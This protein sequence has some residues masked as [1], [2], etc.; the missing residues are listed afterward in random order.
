V[1]SRVELVEHLCAEIRSI[2]QSDLRPQLDAELQRILESDQFRTSHRSCTFLVHVVDRALAGEFDALKERVL[3]TDLFGRDATFDTEHDS[4]VRVAANDVRKR[5][6]EFYREHEPV[7]V[8]I[9]L[10]AGLY[11]PQIERLE[12]Q[13]APPAA[14]RPLRP[15]LGWSLALTAVLLAAIL[16]WVALRQRT[17]VPLAATA[18]KVPF[19]SAI[20]KTG[21]RVNIVTADANLVMMKVRSGHDVPISEYASHN[22]PYVSDLPGAF[23]EYLN[24][25]PLTTVSDALIATRITELATAAGSG[26]QVVYCNRLTVGDLKGDLPV[27]LLGSPTSNPWVEL[28]YNQLN[29]QLVHRY[30]SGREVCVNRQPQAGEP[31]EYLPARRR[32][33]FSEGY[34]VVSMVPNLAG[35]APVLII[36]GTSTEGTEAAGDFVTNPDRLAAWARKVGLDRRPNLR[37]LELVIRASYVSAASA[38]SDVVA[39]RATE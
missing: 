36:A 29:F 23:G 24:A 11:I 13:P 4:V 8:R 16:L 38:T 19:W 34:A 32:V 6:K 27:V 20:L 22:L 3:G 10:P 33:G 5:L 37:R 31:P 14:R 30:D 1:Q 26:A 39:F 28:F 17:P 15:K 7:N 21:K 2:S 9:G 18:A 25:I 12:P 35:K